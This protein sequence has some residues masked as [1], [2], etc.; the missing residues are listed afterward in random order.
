MSAQ[1]IT[2]IVLAIFGSTGFWSWLTNRQK[3]KSAEAKLLT[4]IAYS[5]IVDQ[6]ERHIARGEI[7]TREFNELEHYL[8]EP[9]HAMG[10]NGTVDKL[11]AQVRALDTRVDDE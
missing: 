10:G 5:K 7:T 6:C 4:G 11:M 2:T 3:S 8:Y 1:L 9:Y